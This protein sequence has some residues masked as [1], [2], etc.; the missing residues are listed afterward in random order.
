ML[1][2]RNIPLD[3]QNTRKHLFSRPLN[4]FQLIRGSAFTRGLPKPD[5]SQDSAATKVFKKAIADNGIRKSD[6]KNENKNWVKALHDI[7]F[8]GGSTKISHKTRRMLA[9]YLLL[10]FTVGRCHLPRVYVSGEGQRAMASDVCT[11]E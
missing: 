1:I 4:L 3:L 7:W 11:V 2:R 10:K 5:I 6:L 8:N 9:T